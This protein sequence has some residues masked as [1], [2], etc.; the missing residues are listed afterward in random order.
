MWMLSR[1]TKIS[2]HYLSLTSWPDLVWA[3]VCYWGAHENALPSS[4]VGSSFGWCPQQL[5]LRTVHCVCP[6]A[7]FPVDCSQL[8]TDHGGGITTGPFLRDA[9]LLRHMTLIQQLPISWL[10]FSR[11]CAQSQTL[12]IQAPPS[13]SPSQAFNLHCG[14]KAVPASSCSLPF[15]LHGTFPPTSLLHT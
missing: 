8:V 10:N 2:S 1:V 12:P 13:P 11:N 5:A 4:A 15:I 9:G 6:Y 14:L 7:T 3:L